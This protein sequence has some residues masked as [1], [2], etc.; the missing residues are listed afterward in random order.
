MSP[1]IQMEWLALY[2]PLHLSTTHQSHSNIRSYN[3]TVSVD[4]VRAPVHIVRVYMTAILVYIP[5]CS[6]RVYQF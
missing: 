3:Y 5:D 6:I 4:Y 1:P 2:T